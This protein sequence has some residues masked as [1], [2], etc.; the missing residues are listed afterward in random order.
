[1]L[2]AITR[3]PSPALARCAL[4]YLDRCTIDPERAIAQHAVYEE[5]L[6]RLGVTVHSLP[7]EPDLPD[8]VFLE[9][10]AVVVNEL[11]VISHP[12]L[13]SRQPETESVS[14]ALAPFRMLHRL[15]S[16]ASLEG[17]DVM[18]IGRTVFVGRSGRTNDEGIRQLAAALH[19]IG[20]RVEPVDVTG[21]LHLKTGGTYIGR[22]TILANA[23]WIDTTRFRG[24]DI[25]AVSPDEPWAG[26][27]LLV[28]DTVVLAAGFPR[29][30]ALLTERGFPVETADISEL[31]KA[32]AGLTCCSIVFEAT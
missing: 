12:H 31:A 26:N 15:N 13:P 17:G 24:F 7:P 25:L 4:T 23:A 21:C 10:A 6:R 1:M 28:G 9:D 30:E 22:N 11:A 19:P 32:E 2:H 14:V 27:A 18:R 20:Y 16:H 8:A 5:V 29:T 3:P